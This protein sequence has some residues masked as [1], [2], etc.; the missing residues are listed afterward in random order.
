LDVLLA[1][2]G[3]LLS[4]PI[5]MVAALAIKLEDGGPVFY[6]QERW[7][8]G[9]T[10]FSVLKFRTMDPDSDR[11]VGI[12][13]ARQDDP[14]VTR[15]GTVLRR[16][17]IDEL[18]QL[19]NVLKGEMSLVGPRALAVGE[20]LNT[21]ARAGEGAVQ[22]YDQMPGF[23]ERGSARPG[24]TSLATV[25]LPK[26]VNP[27]KKFRYDLVYVRNRSVGLDVRLI[28]LSVWMSVSGKWESRD[29]KG[30]S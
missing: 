13:M 4:L 23:D 2:A 1:S 10:K 8:R 26:D 25:Y 14:R 5:S 24:L 12:L 22:P 7:G 21:A 27:R 16:M 15:V 17:G 3:L 6:R 18:P 9:S 30:R 28:L 11:R 20:Q 29:G 19:W